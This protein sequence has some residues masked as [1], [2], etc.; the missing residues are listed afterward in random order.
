MMFIYIRHTCMYIRGFPRTT[1]DDCGVTRYGCI[2][3]CINIYIADLINA[4]SS[5][6]VRGKLWDTCI[7]NIGI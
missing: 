6:V 4:K 5:D 7:C 2:N 3:I 1:A